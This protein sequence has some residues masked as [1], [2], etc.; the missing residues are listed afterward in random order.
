MPSAYRPLSRLPTFDPQTGD[1]LAVIETPKHSP[2]K[3]KYDEEYGVFRLAGVMPEGLAFP[4]DFGFI[5]STLG[6]DGDP[7]D[8]LVMLDSPGSVGALLTARLIGAIQVRQREPEGEWVENDR[9]LAVAA[10]DHTH[11][12]IGTVDDLRPALLKEIGAFFAH[13]VRLKGQDLEVTGHA[14]PDHARKLVERGIAAFK[15]KHPEG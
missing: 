5:P 13:Y 10:K 9:L 6:E 12:H 11:E 2:N 4:Y 3:Y 1:L 14:G 15:K 7:V 8:L